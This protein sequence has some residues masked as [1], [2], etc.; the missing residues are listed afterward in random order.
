MGFRHFCGFRAC[1]AKGLNLSVTSVLSFNCEKPYYRVVKNFGL[2]LLFCASPERIAREGEKKSLEQ[3]SAQF[4]YVVALGINWKFR[5]HP[6]HYCA[7]GPIAQH[8]NSRLAAQLSLP[9]PKSV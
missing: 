7:L 6:E 9:R 1:W 2:F 4:A 5:S 3:F 8:H